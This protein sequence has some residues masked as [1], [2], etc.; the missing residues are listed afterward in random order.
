MDTF[1]DTLQKM[2]KIVAD[3]AGVSVN[4]TSLKEGIK[5]IVEFD[6]QIAYFKYKSAQK[7]ATYHDILDVNLNKLDLV[8][9][10]IDWDRYWQEVWPEDML[11]YLEDDPE[12]Y[13]ESPD[14]F[15]ELTKLLLTTE[16]RVVINY[17]L[18]AYVYSR[19]ITLDN[20]F[21]NVS[22]VSS[23]KLTLTPVF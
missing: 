20:R 10:L 5:E 1:E 15:F 12:I 16:P 18:M 13:I 23:P 11:S 6:R 17:V 2:A 7:S 19:S 14:E 3:D 4:E 9:P 21:D 8:F 22:L